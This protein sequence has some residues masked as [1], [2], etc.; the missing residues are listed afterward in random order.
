MLADIRVLELSAPPTM[1]AGQILGDLGADVITVEPPAGSAGRRLAPFIDGR[2]GL[3]RSLTWH[4]LNRNKRGITLDPRTPDGR[5]VLAELIRRVD[6]VIE[7]VEGEDSLCGLAR[8]DQLIV[9]DVTAFSRT[10]PKAAYRATDPVLIA[11]GAS[12][13]MAGPPGRPPL[14]F[15][16][17]Q[18]IMEAGAEAAVAALAALGAR[19]RHGVGQRVDVQA[20][21]AVMPATLGRLVSA[22]SGGPHS[23]RMEPPRMGAMPLIPGIYECRDGHAVVTVVFSPAFVG[24]TQ[25]IA[26]WL[27]EEGFLEREIAALDFMATA[28][29]VMTGEAPA[30][31]IERFVAALIAG[32][33][34]RTK[35]EITE[36]SKRFRFMAAPVMTMADVADFEHYRARGLFAPQAVGDRTVQAPAR[37]AQFSNYEI[38]VRRPAP[39]LS[40]HTLEVLTELAGL[41]PTE[42]Q[43]LFAQGVL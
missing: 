22:R 9:C 18:G 6:I 31:P 21:I 32:C 11:A 26:E 23:R 40:E 29:A 5:A 43:A 34:A 4:A 2:P 13:A 27:A 37:F 17:P 42:V 14:F 38:A 36:A 41:S 12:P 39:G 15:P 24:L 33:K 16:V 25:R 19:D 30:A 35:A 10:G 7:A 8:P 28:R 1:L 20:R 3:E